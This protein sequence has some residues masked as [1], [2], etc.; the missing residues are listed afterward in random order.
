MVKSKK[1]SKSTVAIVLLSLLLVLSLI[2][3]ATG[4]WFTAKDDATTG[5]GS[6]VSFG[7]LG[8][9]TLTAGN[10]EWKDAAGTA[11]EDRTYY[12]PGDKVISASLKIEYSNSGSEASVYYAL[13]DGTNWY[14][15]DAANNKLV[16]ATVAGTIAKGASV[17]IAGTISTVTVDD[18]AYKLDGSTESK[19]IP[20]G[21]QGKT[22]D[23]LAVGLVANG[24]EYSVYVIQS[25][26]V[27]DASEALTLIKAIAA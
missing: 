21:A 7:T 20:N 13:T 23:T 17:E 3:T 19:S 22:L 27:T 14:T 9:V 4:A 12:M 10:A 26:N 5:E 18:T 2:L 15:L 16:S 6:N 1:M 11:V 25:T 24:T 8:A